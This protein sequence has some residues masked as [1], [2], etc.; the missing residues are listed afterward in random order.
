MF[1]GSRAQEWDDWTRNTQFDPHLSSAEK[2]AFQ[3]IYAAEGG[4]KK[5]NTS[6]AVG[7]IMPQT[8]S[9]LKNKGFIDHVGASKT[10]DLDMHD[11]KNVYKAHFDDV[12]HGAAKTAGISGQGHK[13]LDTIGDDEITSAAADTLF[14]DSYK[15][16]SE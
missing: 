6:S 13:M 8:L 15:K 9:D 3:D 14:R 11:L 5:N 1:S 7:G 10:T 16:T 4:M 2:K 12:F